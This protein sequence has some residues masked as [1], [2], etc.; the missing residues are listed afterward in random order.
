LLLS[1]CFYRFAFIVSI[2]IPIR[3]Y[4]NRIAIAIKIS[5]T[6]LL[7]RNRISFTILLLP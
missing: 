1:F 3:F 7:L 4:P 5:I 2:F 6:I